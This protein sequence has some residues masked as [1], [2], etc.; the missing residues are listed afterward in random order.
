MKDL[1]IFQKRTNFFHFNLDL[2]RIIQLLMQ[3]LDQGLFN[4]GIFVYHKIA[5]NTV[6]RNTLHGKPEH[7]HYGTFYQ[8]SSVKYLEIKIDQQLKWNNYINI[9]AIKLNKANMMLYNA[10][11]KILI[12][13]MIKGQK[14]L[15]KLN[16]KNHRYVKKVGQT[17][18]FLFGIY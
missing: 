4:C 11:F 7:Q 1:Q 14:C 10:F 17:S 18:E 3:A 12:F 16:F 13:G 2:N 9:F 15:M 6:D 8:T 5:F